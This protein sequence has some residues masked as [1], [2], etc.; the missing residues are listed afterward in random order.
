MKALFLTIILAVMPFV[1]NATAEDSPIAVSIAVPLS[2]NGERIIKY[3]ERIPHF[4]VIV[5]NV[6]DKP[7]RIF[8]EWNLWGYHGLSFE[9]TDM[10]GKKWV[11]KKKPTRFNMNFP[12]FWTLDPHQSMVMEVFFADL[13]TWEG[14]PL[15]ESGSQTV[16]MRAIFAFKPDDES[17]KL[18]VWTGSVVSKADKFTFYHWKPDAK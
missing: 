1:A 18:G 12:E 3:P 15:P 14:F 5:S 9:I 2:E 8:Q 11:A 13:D 17:R 6:S 10:H 4:H 7:Q 16:T